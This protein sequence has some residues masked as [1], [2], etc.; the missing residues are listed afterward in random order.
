MESTPKVIK[1]PAKIF[2][3][4]Q[5]QNCR[6]IRVAAYCR[7][8]TKEEDQAN[9][10][11]A[12]KEYY[13]DK[14]MK[15][16]EWS[17]AGIFADKGITGTSA[18]KRGDFMRMIKHCRQKK[19][20]V[21]LTKSVSRFS[22]NTVDCLYYIRALKALGIA[23]IFEKE[24]INSL[25][26]DSE[27]RITLSGAFAQS[28][29]ESIS[30]NVTWGKRRAMEAGK[31]YFN[32]KRTYGYRRGPDEKPE[33]IPEQAEVIRQIYDRYLAGASLRGI[34]EA[35]KTGKIPI[36]E[37]S[38]NWTLSHIQSV[39]RN[40]KYC[41]DVLLQKTFRQD[42]INRKRIK[43]TGQLPMYLIENHHPGI[44]TREQFQAVQTETARRKAIKAS[45]KYASTGLSSYA[46]KYALTER[47]F[48]GECGTRYR[49]CTWVIHDEKR[50]VWRC[51]S[52][53]DYGKKYCHHSPTMN[54]TAIQ[55]SILAAINSAMSDRLVLIQQ[56]T[57]AM[58]SELVQI[59]GTSTS[60]GDI[61]R[62]LEELAIQFQCLLEQ[63][64]NDPLAYEDRFKR[65]LDEQTALKEQR[66]AALAADKNL[67]QAGQR[68]KE[69][70]CLL[71][72]SSAI[73]TKWDE[74]VIR[75]LVE[76]VKVISKEQLL[77]TLKGGVQ[78]QQSVIE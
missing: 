75:Q 25:E 8:S 68:V 55:K 36:T 16:P 58:E 44:V 39:L 17:M 4:T 12:Q 56:I 34:Q 21:I 42:F 52:R 23:V 1:I 65:I 35:L 45:S 71:E 5:A 29:S 78:I 62:W 70:R 73:I 59:P 54:E 46:S 24:N 66:A 50:I 72:K 53:L 30:A 9:S 37:E 40:E 69:G 15:N 41:G 47:L 11:E 77:V 67:E 48:C 32:Y 49:R 6:Q 22:R 28:E 10:Y 18:K 51:I 31:V 19:I 3:E 27:M 61:D 60:L 76:S 38:P 33:I 7:V 57:K 13:T 2:P 64:A 63:A 74:S 14:I 20:D 26:E 43:N